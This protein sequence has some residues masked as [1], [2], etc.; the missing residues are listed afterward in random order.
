MKNE[1][2]SK[3]NA[4]PSKHLSTQD[5]CRGRRLDPYSLNGRLLGEQVHRAYALIQV[6]ARGFAHWDIGRGECAFDLA[7]PV[8]HRR[9]KRHERVCCG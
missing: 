5:E 1:S 8:K 7:R 6:K 9:G 2:A 4:T 3:P